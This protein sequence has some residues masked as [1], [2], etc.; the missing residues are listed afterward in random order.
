MALPRKHRLGFTAFLPT[1]EATAN[2]C[3]KMVASSAVTK[4]STPFTA[5][6]YTCTTSFLSGRA[7]SDQRQSI[8][9]A[10]TMLDVDQPSICIQIHR[11]GFDI[12]PPQGANRLMLGSRVQPEPAG[13]GYAYRAEVPD[14]PESAVNGIKKAIVCMTSSNGRRASRLLLQ[15]YDRTLFSM[16][17]ERSPLRRC[18]ARPARPAFEG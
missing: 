17:G 1:C 16:S 7:P 6:R 5:S 13:A 12:G 10:K 9:S 11:S 3:F 4:S 15:R 8:F 18:W 14:T 2:L